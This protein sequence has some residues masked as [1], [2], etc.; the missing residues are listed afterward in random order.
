MEE[1]INRIKQSE[2][3]KGWRILQGIRIRN[4]VLSVIPSLNKKYSK[5]STLLIQWE[6]ESKPMPPH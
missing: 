3:L 6:N 2:V 5:G 4:W 1:N